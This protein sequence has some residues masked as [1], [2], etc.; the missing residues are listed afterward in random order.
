MINL[1]IWAKFRTSLSSAT[2]FDF[3]KN[4]VGENG[5]WHNF[6]QAITKSETKED[7][8]SNLENLLT[9]NNIFDVNLL[10]SR[11]ISRTYRMD[12]SRALI[13][14]SQLVVKAI[15]EMY[16]FKSDNKF[17]FIKNLFVTKGVEV[18]STDLDL[19]KKR[20]FRKVSI[21]LSDG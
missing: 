14:S 12:P 5:F 9:Q 11:Y 21:S 16:W 17:A 19:T 13:E 4:L 6:Y 8:L 10:H 7:F 2:L 1:D 3:D 20:R 15:K 18:I